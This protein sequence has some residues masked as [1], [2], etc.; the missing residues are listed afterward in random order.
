MNDQPKPDL[1][2]VYMTKGYRPTGPIIAKDG[3]MA[4]KAQ[5]VAVVTGSSSVKPPP[6]QQSKQK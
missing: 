5:A 3:H 4:P 1:S 2:G 6:Q